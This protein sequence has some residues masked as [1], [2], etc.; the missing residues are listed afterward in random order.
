MGQWFEAAV[1]STCPHYMQRKRGNP[2]IVAVQLQHVASESNF[3]MTA[4][5][6][7]YQTHIHDASTHTHTHTL[8][9]V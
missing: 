6:I 7:R 8:K 4:T 3:T 2:V 5:T 1:V 9:N